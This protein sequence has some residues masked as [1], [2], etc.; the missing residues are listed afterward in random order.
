MGVDP[1]SPFYLYVQKEKNKPTN[2]MLVKQG[3]LKD[4]K[5]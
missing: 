2:S 4:N 5:D 3:L 1:G